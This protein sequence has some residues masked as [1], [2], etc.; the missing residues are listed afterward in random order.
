MRDSVL[1]AI[2]QGSLVVYICGF[3]REALSLPSDLSRPLQAWGRLQPEQQERIQTSGLARFHVPDDR[4]YKLAQQNQ[5][6]IFERSEV[7]RKWIV[8]PAV[9]QVASIIVNELFNLRV[10][11]AIDV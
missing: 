3:G 10:I 6:E 9:E 5:L 8:V 7:T 11:L 2:H 1:F 4:L